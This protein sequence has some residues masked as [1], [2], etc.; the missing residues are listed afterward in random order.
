MHSPTLFVLSTILMAL[1]TT[2]LSA[3]WYFN[4]NIPGLRPWMLSYGLGF[5]ACIL[6][7]VHQHLPL[8]LSVVLAQ[9]TILSGA[10][11]YLW[12]CSVHTGRRLVSVRFTVVFIALLVAL[13]LYFALVQ[14]QLQVRFWLAGLGT[15]TFFL[16]TARTLAHGDR[17]QV[18]MRYLVALVAALHGVFLLLRPLLAPLGEEKT[19]TTELVALLSHFI[20]LEFVV[21]LMLMAFGTLMLANEFITNELRHLA[22]VDPLTSVFNRRAFL[23]LLD[24]AISQAQRT[25]TALSVLVIDLDYFKKINDTWGH[26]GGDEVLRH[27]V[28]TSAGCLRQQDVMGRLGGEEFAIFLPVTDGPGA[29]VVAE[30]LRATVAAQPV[31][32]HQG[33]MPLTVSIG[34]TL[35]APGD[36]RESVLRRADQAMYLAKENGRNRVEL[37]EQAPEQG[38]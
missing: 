1:V 34:L 4:R 13:S 37:M 31:I 28:H 14:P 3:V 23:L 8:A 11:L 24:K 12:G 6:L 33:R 9:G 21:A 20:L 18:P 29:S 26:Q 38:R 5:G 15:G 22:E 36:S 16:L 10:G 35:C 7:L 30:R 25:G 2:V 19:I 27:F 17:Q 32:G